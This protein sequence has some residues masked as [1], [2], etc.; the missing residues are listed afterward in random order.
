MWCQSGL[1]DRSV[2]NLSRSES[3]PVARPAR[4]FF[5]WPWYKLGIHARVVAVAK[6]N[7]KSFKNDGTQYALQLSEK[8]DKSRGIPVRHDLEQ[9]LLGYTEAT[10]INKGPLFR[11]A[12]RRTKQLKAKA[13]GGIDICR[14][15][16]RRLK[17]AGLPDQFSPHSS[18]VATVIDLLEQNTPLEDVQHLAATP[19]RGR[20]GSMTGDG[21]R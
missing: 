16:K 11:R 21:G 5:L 14:M 20:P 17:A 15:M 3:R 6:L 9:F 12:D 19:T 4:P 10:K 8:G 1:S 2:L 7:L 18:R 13:M